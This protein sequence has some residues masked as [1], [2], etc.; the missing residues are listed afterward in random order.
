MIMICMDTSL[1]IYLAVVTIDLFYE[2]VDECQDHVY[3]WLVCIS[4][5]D[6]IHMYCK[7]CSLIVTQSWQLN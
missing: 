1:F 7:P 2:F 5:V 6:Y 3:F 4:I